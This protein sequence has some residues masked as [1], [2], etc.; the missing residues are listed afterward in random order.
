M[1]FTVT[2]VHGLPEQALLSVRVGDVRQQIPPKPGEELHFDPERLPWLFSVDVLEKIGS[3]QVWLSDLSPADGGDM[4]PEDGVV[5]HTCE[6]QGS[7]DVP[8]SDGA[9]PMRLSA[10]IAVTPTTIAAPGGATVNSERPA[11][12]DALAADKA[13]TKPTTPFCGTGKVAAVAARGYVDIH[14]VQDILRDMVHRLLDQKPQDAVGFMIGYL[15]DLPPTTTAPQTVES[16]KPEVDEVTVGIGPGELLD[17]ACID[18]LG[19]HEYPGF[20]ADICPEK[21][22]DLKRHHNV[23][24]TTVRNDPSIYDRLKSLRTQGGVSLARCIKPG[25]DNYGHPMIK[26]AGI[27]AGDAECFEVFKELMDPALKVL[28]AGFSPDSPLHPPSEMRPAETHDLELDLDASGRRVEC[29]RVRLGR[30]LAGLPLTTSMTVAQRRE[31]EQRLAGAFLKLGGELEGHYYPLRGSSTYPGRPGGMSLAE[32]EQ[33]RDAD[34]LF[35]APTSALILSSGAGRNWPEARGVFLSRR[36]NFMAWVNSEEDHLRLTAWGKGGDLWSV[37]SRAAEVEMLLGESI[38]GGGGFTRSPRLGY[39]S[40]FPENVGTGMRIEVFAKFVL[41]S[42]DKRLRAFAK[43][44]GLLIRRAADV[45]DDVWEIQNSKRF[46]VTEVEQAEAVVKGTRR[47]LQ[48]EAA[49]ERGE[50]IDD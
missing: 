39:L 9:S 13:A 50:Q 23:M 28:H 41:L 27:Y 26:M 44:C 33:L 12:A 48:A 35:D 5:K 10:R 3:T 8:R 29:V 25:I 17:F 38:S 21:L 40:A 31:V 7:F 11:T 4:P 49:L 45:G 46:G 20:S 15:Q 42:A 24:A 37:L 14:G 18:G 43:Q 16:R 2:E 22:P 19:D 6:L 30:N 1:D 32:E 47:L 34:A 36:G